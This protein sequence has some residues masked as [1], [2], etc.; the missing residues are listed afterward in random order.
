MTSWAPARPRKTRPTA[1]GKCALLTFGRFANNLSRCIAGEATGDVG[2]ML[3]Y[4]TFRD[5]VKSGKVV[6]RIH[7]GGESKDDL[8]S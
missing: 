1:E 5:R 2:Q 4:V 3:F 6:R 7:T 8:L